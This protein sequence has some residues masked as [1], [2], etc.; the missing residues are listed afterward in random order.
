[1]IVGRNQTPE[2]P[3]WGNLFEWTWRFRQKNFLYGRLESVDRDMYEL[4]HKHQRAQGVPRERTLVQA[5]TVGFVRNVPLI[6]E[7]E[8]GIGGDLTAY[9]FSSRLDPVYGRRPLSLHGFLRVRFGSHEDHER[10][11]EPG[12]A[13]HEMSK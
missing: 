3:E 1:M 6:S 13:G 2:G 12:H 8:T 10:G 9:R 11:A 7:A 4:V 5:A